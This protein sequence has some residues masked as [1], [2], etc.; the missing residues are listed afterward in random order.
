MKI[1]ECSGNFC[2]IETSSILVDT[3][4]WSGLEGSEKLASTAVFHAEIEVVFGLERMIEGDDEWMVAGGQDLLLGQRS[5]DL[6][7]LDHLLLA[8]DCTVS[9]CRCFAI[10][11]GLCTHPSWRIA[12]HSSFRAPG[13]PFRHLP[14]QST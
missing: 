4:V 11:I 9:K 5:L 6:V 8:E 10:I 14:C 7:A 3:F 2:S 13:I 1:L 12:L